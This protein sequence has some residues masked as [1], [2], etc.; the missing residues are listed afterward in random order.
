MSTFTL[1][2]QPETVT[3]VVRGVSPSTCYVLQVDARYPHTG[4]RA[5]SECKAP[6]RCRSGAS[7]GAPSAVPA[8]CD[9]LSESGARAAPQQP[10]RAPERGRQRPW[11]SQGAWRCRRL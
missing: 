5:F 8:A 10:P 9:G 7:R 1:E 6:P 11:G 2:K 4:K 3:A